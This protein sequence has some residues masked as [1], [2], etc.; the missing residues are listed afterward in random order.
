M[1]PQ[2]L[3]SNLSVPP[4]LSL[5]LPPTVLPPASLSLFHLPL[6]SRETGPRCPVDNTRVSYHQL[7][8][9][10]FAKREV[11]SL[12]VRCSADDAGCK[13][14]GELRD[15]EVSHTHFLTLGMCAGGLQ[16]LVC[17]L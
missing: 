1:F 16:Y 12:N 14:H 6:S 8:K 5:S 11:L 7:F 4:P 17:V 10:N 3:H 13:W 15:L 9:D 2:F